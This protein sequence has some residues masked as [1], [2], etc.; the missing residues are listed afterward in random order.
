MNTSQPP[1][2]NLVPGQQPLPTSLGYDLTQEPAFDDSFLT[3]DEFT[4]NVLA[5]NSYFSYEP[6]PTTVLDEAPN[7]PAITPIGSM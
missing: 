2:Y 3:F 6:A 7:L 1:D 5:D 4:Q